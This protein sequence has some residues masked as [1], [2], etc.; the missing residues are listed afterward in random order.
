[1]KS[2]L[3]SILIWI[4]ALILPVVFF[5]EIADNLN[6][7][8]PVLPFIVCPLLCA[9]AGWLTAKNLFWVITGAAIGLAEAA[10]LVFL[11]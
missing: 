2:Q 11:V 1:M 4:V 9:A 7:R 3:V 5:V 8:A 6:E 10:A